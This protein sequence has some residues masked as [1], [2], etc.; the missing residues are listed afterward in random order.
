MA[1]HEPRSAR[2][3]LQRAR[4]VE[5][6]RHRRRLRRRVR[7]IPDR[8]A[9]PAVVVEARE[10][11]VVRRGR[12]RQR[13]DTVEGDELREDACE[14]E[15][16]EKHRDPDDHPEEHQ[17]RAGAIAARPGPA[18]HPVERLA[19]ERE[20]RDE[21]GRAGDPEGEHLLGDLEQR[22]G[23]QDGRDGGD[24]RRERHAGEHL[25]D[26]LPARAHGRR[27]SQQQRR[28]AAKRRTLRTRRENG[29]FGSHWS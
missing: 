14:A 11:D 13:L 1:R 27:I 21:D 26:E 15:E 8:L 4:E 7:G 25:R 2:A 10:P 22:A 20:P 5:V 28:G 19:P 12:G 3:R 16:E 9:R 29:S 23:L 17:A 24:R 18:P 6:E